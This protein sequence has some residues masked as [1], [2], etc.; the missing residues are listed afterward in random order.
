MCGRQIIMADE[1]LAGWWAREARHVDEMSDAEGADLQATIDRGER[2]RVASLE[3][4]V[5]SGTLTPDGR[6]RIAEFPPTAVPRRD[7]VRP[8]SRRP[9]CRCFG[10]ASAA[11]NLL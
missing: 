11:A 4:E 10:S 8:T 3:A 7:D 2:L 9:T 5:A 1:Y 6:R